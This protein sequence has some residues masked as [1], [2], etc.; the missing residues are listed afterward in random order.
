MAAA[1]CYCKKFARFRISPSRLYNTMVNLFVVYC[2]TIQKA[3][4]MVTVYVYIEPKKKH[5]LRMSDIQYWVHGLV[6][7]GG[8]LHWISILYTSE[9]RSICEFFFS[10]F[11]HWVLLNC[12]NVSF[13]FGLLSLEIYRKIFN[14]RAY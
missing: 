11:V 3:N 10:C 8:Y 12:S 2:I 14:F 13:T 4:V 1:L 5:T 9:H 7:F 6:M